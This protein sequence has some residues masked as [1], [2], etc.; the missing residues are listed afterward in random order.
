MPSSFK[1]IELP[2]T[3]PQRFFI[4]CLLAM[5]GY[6]IAKFTEERAHIQA[7]RKLIPHQII[8]HKLAGLENYTKGVAV[9]GYYTDTPES[10][11]AQAKLFTYA[12]Y[13]LAPTILDY[14]NVD[15]E[16]VLFVCNNPE[17][18]LKIIGQIHAEPFKQNKYGMILAKLRL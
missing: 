5:T 13:L 8:G 4:L 16:Y 18:A 17:N 2:R 9:M 14:N 3:W 7:M 6:S 12:Q 15:H 11:E 1:N 10:D